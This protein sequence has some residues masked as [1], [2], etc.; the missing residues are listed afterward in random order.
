MHSLLL[1]SQRL[2]A[3]SFL[4]ELKKKKKKEGRDATYSTRQKKSGVLGGVLPDLPLVHN[5]ILNM[6]L[7]IYIH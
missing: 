2:F 6:L 3:K 7:L 4:K 5:V 1:K